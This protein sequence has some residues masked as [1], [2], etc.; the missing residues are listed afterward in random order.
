MKGTNKKRSK[1]LKKQRGYTISKESSQAAACSR[2][3]RK[4]P[5]TSE[6][7]DT[8]PG[9]GNEELRKRKSAL[10]AT[11]GQ[12]E[13]KSVPGNRYLVPSVK[14]EQKRRSVLDARKGRVTPVPE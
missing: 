1:L 7:K 3:R 11:A 2:C 4:S 12:F 10:T 6:E 13:K 14:R 9:T 5:G 8:E